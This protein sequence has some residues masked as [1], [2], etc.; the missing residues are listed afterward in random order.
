MRPSY[1]YLRY[2]P[3]DPKRVV[4]R[5]QA[6]LVAVV[7]TEMREH[8]VALI[9][10]SRSGARLA[11]KSLP[12]VGEQLTFRAEDVKAYGE[13]VWSVGGTCAVEFDT[14][15]AAVEV[16]YLRCAAAGSELGL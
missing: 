15:I 8:R 12:E 10:V 5:A 11:G 4:P 6:P 13:V 9:D 3:G 2:L 14:P 16:E 1:A 7:A